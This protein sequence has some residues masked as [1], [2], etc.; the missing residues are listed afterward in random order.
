MDYI[1]L[2]LPLQ[3]PL[4]V[5]ATRHIMQQSAVKIKTRSWENIYKRQKQH[6]P[7][8]ALLLSFL[9]V[10]CHTTDNNGSNN[11]KQ[12]RCIPIGTPVASWWLCVRAGDREASNI[13]RCVALMS[14]TRYTIVAVYSMYCCCAFLF[15]LLG[16]QVCSQLR[17]YSFCCW[18][19]ALSYCVMMRDWLRHKQA[20]RRAAAD[21]E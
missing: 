21:E 7:Q 17:W 12:L 5:T 4:P 6:Q 19:C 15:L 18:C 3:L 9:L 20:S 13:E 14:A 10:H 2:P 11:E 16:W 1:T 8:D